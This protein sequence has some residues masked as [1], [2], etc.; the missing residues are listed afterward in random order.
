MRAGLKRRAQGHQR[1]LLAGASIDQHQ[2][3]ILLMAPISGA[4]NI[5]HYAQPMELPRCVH[6]GFLFMIDLIIRPYTL[7]A[8]F[9]S[10]LLT[11]PESR[12]VGC[13]NHFS[14]PA[15]DL[16]PYVSEQNVQV[17]DWKELDQSFYIQL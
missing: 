14:I 10:I 3:H 11:C 4:H 2:S 16:E 8:S 17:M 5:R 12:N 15:L 13:A 1:A 9:E 6:G 7:E